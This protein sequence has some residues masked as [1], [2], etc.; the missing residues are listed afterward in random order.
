MHAPEARRLRCYALLDDAAVTLGLRFLVAGDRIAV[1]IAQ[2][3]K[4]DLHERTVAN[5]HVPERLVPAL[6]VHRRMSE[7]DKQDDAATESVEELPE[8]VRD[9]LP[10]DLDASRFV[11]PY[12]FPDNSRRRYPAVM[13]AILGVACFAAWAARSGD[14]PV[15]V[16]RGFAIVGVALVLVALYIWTS[17]WR[18]RTNEK[19][20]L[21]IATR[22]VG[23]AV[24]HASAQLGWRGLRSRPTW[25]ILV[26]SSEE[27]PAR[28]GFVLIDAVHG[29]V[30]AKFTE[31]NPEEWEDRP[32]DR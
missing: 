19:E 1:V 25:R 11:G 29:L 16:N 27:P 4:P 24:G 3:E 5:L 12:Q 9:E 15:L 26:Y 32:T 8:E 21:L 2:R 20:A 31:D 14:N 17:S 6:Y 13:Y 7:P 28:R 30:V 23:F 22:E 18:M 10:E